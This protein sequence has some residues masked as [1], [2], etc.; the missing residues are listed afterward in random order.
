MKKILFGFAV[1]ALIV[2]CKKEKSDTVSDPHVANANCGS[3]HTTEM[4]LWSSAADLH[5]LSAADVLTNVDHN[6]TELLNDDCLKCH[7]IFQYTLGVA[8]FVTPVDTIGSPAGTWTAMNAADWQATKCEVCHNPSATNKDKLAKYG[9]VLDGQ[10]NADYSSVSDL[11]DAYQ[12]VLNMSTSTISTYVYPDQT[13]LSVQATKLCNSCHD[14]AD[15]GGDPEVVI[16]GVNFGPQGGDSRSF[17]AKNHQGFGCIDCHDSHTFQ[18][19]DPKSTVACRGCH[20]LG[21]ATGK[22][23]INHML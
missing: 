20:S 6:T 11:P 2:S 22:V 7:S 5:A 3:C 10:W 17:V 16:G 23:H 12:K 21:N 8:H 9:S 14:P 13:I 1:I 18:P 4:S 15:Q 19:V